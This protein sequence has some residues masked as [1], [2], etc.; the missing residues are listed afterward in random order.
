M[1]EPEKPGERIE[2]VR[3]ANG[4]RV[5]SWAFHPPS[6]EQR[7]MGRDHYSTLALARQFAAMLSKATGSPIIEAAQ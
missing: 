5:D 2:I 3:L 4:A 7:L 1:G 6:G